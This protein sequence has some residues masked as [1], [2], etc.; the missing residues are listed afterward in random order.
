MQFVDKYWRLT[1][2][3]AMVLALVAART[4]IPAES[5]IVALRFML[6]VV[7]FL[8]L[9][10]PWFEM[11]FTP[12]NW[13]IR[14]SAMWAVCAVAC[15]VIA[16]QMFVWAGWQNTIG[17]IVMLAIAI[18]WTMRAAVNGYKA[19]PPISDN[20]QDARA[21]S[22]FFWELILPATAFLSTF[23]VLEGLLIIEIL[24]A[25]LLLVMAVVQATTRSKVEQCICP[26]TT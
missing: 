25:S 19:M 13:N 23:M 4:L 1:V 18:L 10:L 24:A 15:A 3:V 21:A 6:G 20:L 8:A 9:L 14:Y 17:A 12:E 2:A 26:K 16:A 22:R 5:Q 11:A 7:A